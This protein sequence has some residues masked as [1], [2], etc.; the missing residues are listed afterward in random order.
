MGFSQS[1]SGLNAASTNLDVIGNNIANSATVGFKVATVSFADMFAGS[2]VG[3]GAKVVKVTQNFNDGA[4]IRTNNNLDLAISQDGFF[5]LQ[6]DAGSVYYSRNGQFTRDKDGNII[7]MQGLQLTGYPASGTPPV[8]L[9]GA[10][11]IPLNIPQ[12][13]MLANASTTGEMVVNLNSN[14]TAITT[15]FNA[16][17]PS[18]YHYV[19][20][21]TVFDSLGNPHNL[22]TYFTRTAPG[23]WEVNVMDT[24]LVPPPA[25]TA[26]TF[27][28]NLAFDNQGQ[29]TSGSP[30]VVTIASLNGSAAGSIS[31]DLTGSTQQNAGNAAGS[32]STVKQNGYP[33]GEFVG[34]EIS[35][36][37][38][39]AANFSNQQKKMVGQVVLA[40]FANEQGLR[41]DGD[42][43]WLETADSGTALLGVPESG[44][45]GRL[46]SGALESAN[47]DLGNELVNMIVAQ[48]NYQSNAQSIKTQ[49]SILN[50]LV[51]IR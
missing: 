33:G 49:D 24:S 5:R 14:S 44:S 22:N 8:V 1:V 43:V 41:P 45:F 13:A 17:D 32:T 19:S 42:N 3:M 15:A 9:P 48:R 7:N 11:P 10:Q 16:S 38:T 12:D 23:A 46:T 51:N 29:L 25:P 20:T 34:F 47:V 36:D 37:G 31:I 40:T 6:N 50:T 27:T 21:M 26:P 30:L 4:P 35:R 28:G 18:T 2:G 39:I